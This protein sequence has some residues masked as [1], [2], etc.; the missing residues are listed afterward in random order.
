MTNDIERL[1]YRELS[2]HKPLFLDYL[3]QFERLAPFFSGDIREPGAWRRVADAVSDYPR[4]TQDLAEILREQ[5]ARLG[6]D[7]AVS[8]TIDSFEKGALAVVTGQQVGLL[9]GPL[10]S[11]YKALTAVELARVV[12]SRLG[13]P[14]V[15]IFWMDADDHDF[16]EVRS[17]SLIDASQELTTLRYQPAHQVEALPVGDLHL[18]E[19]IDPLIAQIADRLASSEF[20][21]PVLEAVKDSYQPGKTLAEAFGAWLLRMTRGTGLAVLDPTAPSVKSLARPIFR[22]EIAEGG[23]SSRLVAQTTA[24]LVAQ[25]YHAQADVA[26]DRLNLL[27]A[28]PTRSHI[29]IESSGFRL[30]PHRAPIRSNELQRLVDEEPQRFSGNVIL[31]SIVQDHLLPTL[32]FVA[33]P[34]EIAY[35]SQ[36]GGVYNQF[37]V[38]RPLIAPRASLTLVEKQAAKFLRHYDLK[39]GDLRVD[40]ESALNDILK[41]LAPPELE[42]DLSRARSCINEITLT[43]EKDLT[44]IDPTLASTA[45]STRGRLLHQIEELEAKGRRA[46]KK[47][48]DTLRRQF[49]A[50]RTSLFPNFEM[51]ERRLSP[52]H[53]FAKY[54]WHLTDMIRASIDIEQPGH[55]LLYL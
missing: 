39:F 23:K 10:Y 40:D 11:L 24:E 35:L 29:T 4:P 50:A 55:I 53:Y 49:L 28:D 32:A 45:R 27:C 22:R 48:N 12:G 41:D 5:N 37:G 43:L 3:Y 54:G 17:F 18:D 52:V 30:A 31:R 36:L 14:V 15:A 7:A 38:P 42:E 33:G 34:N 21:Q 13:R 16:E 51:Q 6:S 26:D 9:G 44:A 2:F 25:G 19:S 46:I 20:K 47:K 8:Q 1:D